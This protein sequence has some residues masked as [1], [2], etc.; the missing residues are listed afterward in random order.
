MHLVL[1]DLA[2]TGTKEIAESSDAAAD[3]ASSTAASEIADADAAAENNAAT[4][5]QSSPP[6][7]GAENAQSQDLNSTNKLVP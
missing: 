7:N 4:A 6:K 1:I 5:G 3:H 2:S